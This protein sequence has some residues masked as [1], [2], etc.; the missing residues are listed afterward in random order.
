[1]QGFVRVV[2][3]IYLVFLTVLLLVADP[4]RLAGMRDNSSG[5]FRMIIPVAHLVSFWGLTVLALIVRWPIPRWSLALFLV[6]YAGVTEVLQSCL[7]PRQAEWG[8]WFQDIGGIAL[9]VA[10]C[11]T[12]TFALGKCSG[13]RMRPRNTGG[14]RAS[15]EWEV[16]RNVMSRP[17]IRDET[18]WR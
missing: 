8:D 2:F 9:G 17:P 1:M 15:D 12:S 4:M 11:W 16:V 3:F 6:L 10:I 18:W 5:L 14:P 13:K 7:P